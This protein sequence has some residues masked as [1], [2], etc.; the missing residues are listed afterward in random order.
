MISK[1]QIISK[2]LIKVWEDFHF[3]GI[4]I[5]N[6]VC[7]WRIR[8]IYQFQGSNFSFIWMWNYST[9]F[10]VTTFTTATATG[11][12]THSCSL[13]LLHVLHF[14]V[15][16]WFIYSYNKLLRLVGIISLSPF[17]R[18][19]NWCPEQLRKWF[20]DPSPVLFPLFWYLLCK[21]EIGYLSYHT[22]KANWRVKL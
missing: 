8:P 11:T 17:C 13:T 22:S 5:F 6:S 7:C 3:M 16:I 4:F 19:G 21:T 1:V 18:W 14:A 10:L 2:W 9:L 20:L 15:Y 12:H